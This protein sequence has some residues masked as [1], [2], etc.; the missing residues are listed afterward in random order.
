MPYVQ[1]SKPGALTA[2]F[3]R[4]RVVIGVVHLPALPG[5]PGYRGAA[6]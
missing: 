3:G 2:L 1:R 5:A 4:A 6:R